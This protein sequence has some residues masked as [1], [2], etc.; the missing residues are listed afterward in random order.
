MF[1]DLYLQ[2]Y[3][4]AVS[5]LNEATAQRCK[6]T[7]KADRILITALNL[8]I[9][10]MFNPE[11]KEN[12]RKKIANRQ[13]SRDELV[14]PLDELIATGEAVFTFIRFV[15]MDEDLK[16]AFYQLEKQFDFYKN[17]VRSSA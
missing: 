16:K 12:D 17:L 2:Y 3:R 5:Y 9:K 6:A 4:Y 7:G 11:N 10:V 14:H 13:T 8:S 1:K 15:R